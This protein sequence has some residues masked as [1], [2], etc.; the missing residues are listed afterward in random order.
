MIS[1]E[2]REAI[3]EAA[4][5]LVQRMV[6][7]ARR[8]RSRHAEHVVC[9]VV[10]ALNYFQMILRGLFDSHIHPTA[11]FGL[12]RTIFD[13][14]CGTSY[15]AAHPER[16]QDYIDFGRFLHLEGD[17][18]LGL[19]A[20]ELEIR[21]PDASELVA[22]FRVSRRMPTWHGQSREQ[23]AMLTGFTEKGA[24]A[25]YKASSQVIHGDALMSLMSVRYTI[26]DGWTDSVFTGPPVEHYRES[27][28]VAV[29][30]FVQLLSN[31]NEALT[32]GREVDVENMKSLIRYG[33]EIQG[34]S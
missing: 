16:F 25:F 12:G 22:R 9:G 3:L 29:V 21:F 8:S 5:V 32:L 27:V 13:I 30:L 23:L 26:Q 11:A 4:H 1:S 17:R 19:S 24:Q 33:G 34:L 10:M 2:G 20:N 15:L 28:A 31:V 7:Q 6:G 14:S 18:V